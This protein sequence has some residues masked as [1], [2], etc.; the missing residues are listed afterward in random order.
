MLACPVHEAMSNLPNAQPL[1]VVASAVLLQHNAVGFPSEHEN[2]KPSAAAGAAEERA[3]PRMIRNFMFDRDFALLGLF[4]F[5]AAKVVLSKGEKWECE[6][7][8]NFH[9]LLYSTLPIICYSSKYTMNAQEANS[10]Q[11]SI[12]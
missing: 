12:E 2:A 4:L 8:G 11:S 6:D 9:P 1:G 3:M 7:S 5:S 10:V